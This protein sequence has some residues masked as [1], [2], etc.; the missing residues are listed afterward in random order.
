VAHSGQ[1]VALLIQ[2][3]DARIFVPVDLG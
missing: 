3:D 2:H 1:H